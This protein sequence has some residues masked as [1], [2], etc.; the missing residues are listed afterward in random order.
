MV[1]L[2]KIFPQKYQNVMICLSFIESEFC[3]DFSSG[4]STTSRNGLWGIKRGQCK[5]EILEDGNITKIDSEVE[6]L[7]VPKINAMCTLQILRE[8]GF[9]YWKAWDQGQ[10]LNWKGPCTATK[11]TTTKKVST[12]KNNAFAITSQTSYASFST[13]SSSASSSISTLTS[14]A[15]GQSSASSSTVA[16]SSGGSGH[17]SGLGTGDHKY[18]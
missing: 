11:E 18:L 7:Y 3:P 6:R 16:T 12:T 14:S 17:S 8:G 13:V 4:N 10:C 9:L 2:V 1:E 5:K 15:T